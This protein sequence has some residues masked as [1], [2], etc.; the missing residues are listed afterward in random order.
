MNITAYLDGSNIR[1][2]WGNGRKQIQACCPM[3]GCN[4]TKF[5]LGINLDKRAANCFNCKWHGSIFKLTKELSGEFIRLDGLG[6]QDGPDRPKVVDLPQEFE[7]LAGVEPAE[8]GYGALVAYMYGR[9]LTDADFQRYHVGG[10]LSGRFAD[11]VIFPVFY[12]VELF[13]FLGRTIHKHVEPRYLNA[14]AATRGVWGLEPAA[15]HGNGWLILSEGVLKAIAMDRVV[16][17]CN[18]ASLGNELS[19]FQLE[20]IEGAGY[21]TVLIIPDPGMAGLSGLYKTADALRGRGIAVYFPWPL[22]VKQADEVPEPERRAWVDNMVEY[23]ATWRL[24]VL[25]ELSR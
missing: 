6:N 12:G 2:R 9:G 4:D 8:Y 19:E 13:T 3:S 11:R 1:W 15:D 14:K 18:A 17:G 16:G 23:N 24:R 7:L 10:A 21:K 20:Q 25:R 5:R 22:P